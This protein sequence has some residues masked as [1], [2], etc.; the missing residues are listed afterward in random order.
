VLLNLFLSFILGQP[1]YVSENRSILFAA[2]ILAY[3]IVFGRDLPTTINK[4]LFV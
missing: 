2:V 4:N 3:M 1:K